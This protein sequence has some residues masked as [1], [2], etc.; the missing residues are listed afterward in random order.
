MK[1]RH[2]AQEIQDSKWTHEELCPENPENQPSIPVVH[3]CGHAG[4]RKRFDDDADGAKARAF[5]AERD[6]SS[7]TIAKY[8]AAQNA[9]TAEQRAEHD[10]ELRAA[11]GPGV[12]VVNVITG[13]RT[14][15]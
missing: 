12:E 15:T 7:C 6:C 2:C 1:C 10:Y 14:T 4:E 3:A 13:R 11:F 8:R 9:M 5:E